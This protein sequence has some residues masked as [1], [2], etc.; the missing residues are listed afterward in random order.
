MI[1]FLAAEPGWAAVVVVA[2]LVSYLPDV[3]GARTPLPGAKAFIVALLALILGLRLLGR[4]L[5]RLPD[6]TSWFWVLLLSLAL[7]GMLAERP[8]ESLAVIASESV[9]LGLAV[10]VLLLI[11]T[12]AWL[13]R[14]VWG[15]VLP[16]AVLAT[17][18][19]AH[20]TTGEGSAYFGLASVIEDHG[21]RRSAGPTDVNFFAQLLITSAALAFYLWRSATERRERAVALACLAVLLVGAVVTYSRG[22]F[23]ALGVGVLV[24]VLLAAKRAWL[25]WSLVVSVAAVAVVAVPPQIQS[26]VSPSDLARQSREQSVQ[27]RLTVNKAATKMFADYPLL[28]VGSGNYPNRFPDYAR[29]LGVEQEDL[30]GGGLGGGGQR[31]H[32]LYLERMAE[33]GIVG[34]LALLAVIVVALRASW[35]ARSRLRGPTGLLCEGVFVALLVYLTASTFLHN[36]YPRYFWIMIALALVPESLAEHRD[37]AGGR[38][39]A[40]QPQAGVAPVR[41]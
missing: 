21:V 17:L 13:R 34:T 22:G 23:L 7:S 11:D 8:G 40:G 39:R 28:G 15:V 19:V 29:E 25:R 14:T 6:R 20:Y 26:L 16:A 2:L 24:V 4:P 1:R 31:P 9:S 37:A 18:G 33:T 35:L 41:A 38:A 30:V 10:C 3:I 36:A 5:A 27:T 32:G 12:P